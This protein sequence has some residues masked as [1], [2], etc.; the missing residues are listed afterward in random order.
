M[1]SYTAVPI[2]LI[3]LLAN[4]AQLGLQ[5]MFEAQKTL[6][7]MLHPLQHRLEGLLPAMQ[8]FFRGLQ[9]SNWV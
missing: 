1:H 4:Q 9:V 3:T 7:N 6:H 5:A 8:S 2:S